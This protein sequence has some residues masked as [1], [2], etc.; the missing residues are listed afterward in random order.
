MPVQIQAVHSNLFL[1][2]KDRKW[3]RPWTNTLRIYENCFTKHIL[4]LRSQGI[5]EVI[6]L[7]QPVLTY[8]CV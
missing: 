8:K 6:D 7:G 3:E 4:E 5:E 1:A 2:R